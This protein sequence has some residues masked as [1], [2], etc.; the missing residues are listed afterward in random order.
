MP[1]LQNEL[2]SICANNCIS[3]RFDR[4]LSEE[5]AFIGLITYSDAAIK[6]KRTAVANLREQTLNVTE[7]VLAAIAE[8]QDRWV[9]RALAAWE[10]ASSKG[11]EF[12]ARSFSWLV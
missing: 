2:T 1:L 11:A 3:R 5:E 4:A 8:Q 6:R 12:G 9:E 10:L 7:C